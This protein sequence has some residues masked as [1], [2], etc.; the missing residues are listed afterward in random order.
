MPARTKAGSPGSV[1]PTGHKRL[2]RKRYFLLHGIKHATVLAPV[3]GWVL[4]MLGK[5]LRV[6]P[7]P[8]YRPP[9]TDPARGGL[10]AA[11]SAPEG[12]PSLRSHQ[13]DGLLPEDFPGCSRAC[14]GY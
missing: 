5:I 4:A 12:R 6:A 7:I 10:S 8:A 13:R 11:R 2:L 14:G 1:S 9:L 3:K